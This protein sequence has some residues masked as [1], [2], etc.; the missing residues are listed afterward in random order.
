MRCMWILCLCTILSCSNA[1]PWKTGFLAN[2]VRVARQAND[3][4]TDLSEADLNAL[5]TNVFGD[6]KITLLIRFI[7]NKLSGL[8]CLV[9]S[10]W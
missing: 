4:P 8:T 1:T 3:A 2:R 7:L 6:G 9:L 5:L 10:L